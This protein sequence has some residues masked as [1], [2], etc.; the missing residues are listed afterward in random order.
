MYVYSRLEHREQNSQ[1]EKLLNLEKRPNIIETFALRAVVLKLSKREL[2]CYC[3]CYCINMLYR[4]IM[5]AVPQVLNNY[6]FVVYK[7]LNV[8]KILMRFP[9]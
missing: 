8:F 6:L 1:N 7:L 5:Y 2:D 9:D 3:C 4:Y